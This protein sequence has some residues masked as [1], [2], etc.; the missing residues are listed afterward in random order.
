MKCVKK[1]TLYYLKNFAAFKLKSKLDE[2]SRLKLTIKY[3]VYKI[4]N[5]EVR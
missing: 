4:Q 3:R 2:Y 1:S 5:F